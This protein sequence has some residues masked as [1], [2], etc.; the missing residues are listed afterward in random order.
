MKKYLVLGVLSLVLAAT[1]VVYAASTANSFVLGNQRTA[2]ILVD[3][4]SDGLENSPDAYQR[5]VFEDNNSVNKFIQAI[6]Y[7]KTFLSGRVY[8]WY[9]LNP[10]DKCRRPYDDE[11]FRLADGDVNF[12]EY[13]R[14]IIIYR[15]PETCSGFGFG[16]SSFGKIPVLTADGRVNIS[17][18]RVFSDTLRQPYD[19]AFITPNSTM[20]HELI[21]GCGVSSHSNFY[22][23][24]GTQITDDIGKCQQFSTWDHF[25]IM[26][27]RGRAS[28]PPAAIMADLGW[29]DPTNILTVTKSGEYVI[30]PLEES[31]TKPLTARIQLSKPIPINTSIKT[32]EPLILSDYWLE[33]RQPLNFDK[34]LFWVFKEF[35]DGQRSKVDTNGL[36]IRGCL[37]VDGLCAFTYLLDATPD[38][39]PKT[40]LVPYLDQSDAIDS[41]LNLGKTFFD[42]VNGIT[43]RPIEITPDGGIRF[44]VNLLP[45]L[46]PVAVR[47]LQVSRDRT[48]GILITWSAPNTAT[49]QTYAVY[50]CVSA[51]ATSCSKINEFAARWSYYLDNQVP[52]GVDYWYAVDVQ[53]SIGGVSDEM[54]WNGVSNFSSPGR[55]SP[56]PPPTLSLADASV[57]EGN[58]GWQKVDLAVT[59]SAPATADIGANFAPADGTAHGDYSPVVS[60]SLFIP[61]GNTSATVT[62]YVKGDTVPEADEH[63]FVRLIN[64]TA[65]ATLAKAEGKVTIIN[66]DGIP[67]PPPPPELTAITIV[68]PNGGEI[69]RK[70]SAEEIVWSFTPASFRELADIKL[71]SRDGKISPVAQNASRSHGSYYWTVGVSGKAVPAGSYKM[72]ICGRENKNICERSDSYF[73][74]VDDTPPPPPPPP[75]LPAPTTLPPAP[76]PR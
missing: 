3:L 41:F 39:L 33:Y 36:L 10:S 29:L 44:E 50:R 27:Q 11:V 68:S 31:T 70:N 74:I 32:A 30:S 60:G 25:S 61:V 62:V 1:S 5:A 73:V 19:F 16:V 53:S 12:K 58:T 2:V 20:A 45:V 42:S 24:Y 14:V 17:V 76:G 15:H 67:P 75:T 59:L 8:G 13:D 47:N 37:Y 21:H 56:P 65:G 57:T 9:R 4:S 38:S 6:S 34:G 52:A 35:S 43:I 26:G 66:D 54:V 28:Y 48:D 71:I 40:G 46:I 72:E 7:G 64:P 51:A 22:D 63:F 55:R 69:L 23:F 49:P 18:S